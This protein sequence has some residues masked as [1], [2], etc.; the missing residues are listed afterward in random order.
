M[1]LVQLTST[2]PEMLLVEEREYIGYRIND[3]DED[4]E[5]S[6]VIGEEVG[7]MTKVLREAFH[8]RTTLKVGKTTGTEICRN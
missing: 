4:L 6:N 7:H 8:V 2:V 5:K 1:V 3:N